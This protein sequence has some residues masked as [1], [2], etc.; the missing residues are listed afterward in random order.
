MLPAIATVLVAF[1]TYIIVSTKLLKIIFTKPIESKG[2]VEIDA[3]E[4]IY[5]HP[6]F[7]DKLQDFSSLGMQTLYDLV[8]SVA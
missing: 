5:A 7:T 8:V 4:H 1:V 6:D 3:N 2:A